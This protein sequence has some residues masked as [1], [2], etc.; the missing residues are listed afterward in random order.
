MT[1]VGHPDFFLHTIHPVRLD[2]HELIADGM[3]IG[4]VFAGG[5]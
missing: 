2:S 4:D 5:G 3:R 1:C